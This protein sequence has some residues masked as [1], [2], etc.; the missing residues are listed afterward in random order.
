M[1]LRLFWMLLCLLSVSTVNVIAQG[2]YYNF[3]KVDIDNGLSHNQVYSIYRDSTGFV[4]FGTG[5][6]L[7]RFDGNNCKVFINNAGDS[8]SLKENYVAEIFPLP[9][10]ELWI[11]SKTDASI[12]YP[13]TEKFNSDFRSYLK[14]LDLPPSRIVHSLKDRRGNYWFL[15]EKEGLFKYSPAS[16]KTSHFSAGS[17]ELKGVSITA[18]NEDTHG[19]LWLIFSTGYLMLIESATLKPLREF[20]DLQKMF[21]NNQYN[22]RIFIDKKNGLWIYISGDPKG[23]YQLNPLTS[24]LNHF[25]TKDVVYR[26]NDNMIMGIIQDKAGAIW[27]G[28]DRG[29]I[30][31]VDGTDYS[32]ITYLINKESDKNSLGYNSIEKLYHDDKGLIWVG[33]GKKGVSYLN[34]NIVQFALYRHE[35]GNKNSLPYNDLNYF[36]ED[37]KGNVWIGTNGGGLIYFDRHKNRFTRYVN[38][39]RNS[40]SLSN[41]VVVSL[42]IDHED[43]LWI[44][45]YHGGMDVFD[46]KTF[47]HYRH[48]VS[49][50]SS[51]GDNRVWHIM[52]DKNQVMWI[53]T[54]RAGLNRFDRKTKKFTRYYFE[55][56]VPKPLHSNY[57]PVIREDR[58]GNLWVG[59]SEGVEVFNKDRTRVTNHRHT[60]NP[61]SLSHQDVQDI[62]I[63]KRDLVW[64]GT[65]NG[66]N[67]WSKTTK[68]FKRFSISDGLPDN[69]ILNIAED[70]KGNLWIT[71]T[72]GICQLIIDNKKEIYFEVRNF[73]ESNNVQGKVFNESAGM[74]SSEGLIFF[75]GSTGFNM[76]DPE[77]VPVSKSMPSLVFTN[78]DII[79]NN[80]NAEESVNKNLILRKASPFASEIMLCYNENIFS[81][82]FSA[83]D[84]S[85]NNQYAYKL[86]GFTKNWMF[87]NNTNRKVTYTNLDPGVYFFKIKATNSDGVWGNEK[88]LKIIITPPFWKTPLAL[89]VYLLIIAGILYL[90]RRYTLEKAHM[91]FEVTQQRKERE[92]I[93]AID[94]VKTKFFTNVS[95]EFRT[96][97]SLILTPLD[98][99]IKFTPDPNHKK[100][101][102]LVQRNAKRL[103]SLVN[104]LLDFRKME[105]QEFKLQSTEGDIIKF[106]KEISYSFSD[107][108]EMKNIHLSFSTNIDSFITYFD[109]D[110][111]EKILFNLLSNAFKYTP[112]KGS[113]EVQMDYL[114]ENPCEESIN[115]IVKDS[116]I[117]IP[118]DKQDR[119]FERFFQ[120][121]VPANITNPGTGI[122]LAIT[123]EFVKLHNGVINVNSEQNKGT[124]FTVSLPMRNVA[125]YH[126]ADQRTQPELITSV[127]EEN[128]GSARTVRSQINK[129][130]PLILLVEDNDDFRFYLKDNLIQEFDVFE[131][132]NGQ[133]AW[134]RLSE[135]RPDLIV[136][137]IMMPHMDGIELSRR[138][139]SSPSLSG[140]PIILLTAVCDEELQ[141]E[142]YKLG[143]SEYITKPFTYEVLASRVKNLLA[144]NKAGGKKG[145]RIMEVDPSPIE[146]LPADERFLKQVLEVVEKNMSNPDFTVEELSKEL[147]MHRAGMYRKLLSLTGISPL[148]FI[149]NI[150][151]KRGRQ[152]LEKSQMTI[153]EIAYEVGFNNP[154]KF[155]Q[156]FKEEFGTTPTNFLKQHLKNV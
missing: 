63:D 21:R 112:S 150:R 61:G 10:G 86:D 38:D 156:H 107:I 91:R 14:K 111:L 12:Y 28:T 87:T 54:L 55:N 26:L 42:C 73:T 62:T 106:T 59:T 34:Q 94:A 139:K 137:D 115:I 133:D 123:K 27:I 136:S 66:L 33:T 48:D 147:F 97:L 3:S 1:P 19:N 17:S 8:T 82:E 121:D 43:K 128:P 72:K 101:L 78:I 56:D 116:G 140:I 9:G 108:S 16:Q 5:S 47:T 98:R 65:R 88:T 138:L 104:Q 124:T 131:A 36:A 74:V 77:K 134:D 102:Q 37:R 142:S 52:E 32:N 125:N 11:G 49:D 39:P 51:I 92:R 118:L 89:I 40:N 22:F 15:F 146:I 44:G 135:L 155:S 105:V 152:L 4:W 84:F 41:N 100:Q 85:G 141:L 68:K 154:K 95:H 144:Q 23:V 60:K 103:L 25:S 57:I 148:E 96:P 113:V 58:E 70:K 64:V 149:R 71:T 80:V 129:V 20:S 6:G 110:K 75:G 114:H 79:D 2:S 119:I 117:G 93:Q 76:I 13:S 143:V 46:G 50:P 69:N 127:R 7:N 67:V 130:R 31:V 122:G 81:I 151:L 45:T 90:A 132:V 120:N 153:S 83:L 24:T 35:T 145:H 126:T 29:G 109:K 30:N 53:G 18:F 99:I